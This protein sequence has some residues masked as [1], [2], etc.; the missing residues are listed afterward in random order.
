MIKKRS[1][2]LKGERERQIIVARESSPP[3]AKL[4]FNFLN[5]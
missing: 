2:G 1:K 3:V 4:F 5:E